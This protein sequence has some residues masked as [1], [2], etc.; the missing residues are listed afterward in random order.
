M[1]AYC[2]YMW[3][4]QFFVRYQVRAADKGKGMAGPR[5]IDDVDED[6]EEAVTGQLMI[7]VKC[8]MFDLLSARV[9]ASHDSRF[10]PS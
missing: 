4:R 2:R 1:S 10:Y 8:D 9:D 7:K 3:D 6:V 5:N